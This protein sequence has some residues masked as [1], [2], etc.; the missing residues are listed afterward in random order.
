MSVYVKDLLERVMTSFIAGFVGAVGLDVTSITDLGWKAWLIA[1]A[2][3]GIVSVVKG[4]LAK[5]VGDSQSASM[6]PSI[7]NRTQ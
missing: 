4:V 1:G 3:A 6:A 7:E 5:G 2:G